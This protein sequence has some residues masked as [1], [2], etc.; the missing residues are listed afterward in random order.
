MHYYVLALIEPTDDPDEITERVDAL[1]APYNDDEQYDL[2]DAD[3]EANAWFAWDWYSI[4]GRWQG[5]LAQAECV[6]C[7]STDDKGWAG[8]RH[9]YTHRTDPEGNTALLPHIREDVEAVHVVSNRG[10][11]GRIDPWRG[12]F[13]GW[14]A[15]GSKDKDAAY[16]LR[17]EEW[18]AQLPSLLGQHVGYLA[19][20]VDCHD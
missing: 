15:L 4:G 6:E 8:S 5:Y 12:D 7:Q 11:W 14:N 3:R 19:V 2:P 13:E 9:V 18:A 1:L 20:G 16:D 10:A 17:G